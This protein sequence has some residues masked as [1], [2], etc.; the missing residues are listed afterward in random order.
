MNSF[1]NGFEKQ[2]GGKAQAAETLLQ[3]T[4]GKPAAASAE[5]A[6]A[7]VKGTG[8]ELK[9]SALNY[10]KENPGKAILGVGSLGL[11]AG[12]L[13]GRRSEPNISNNMNLYRA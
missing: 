5:K 12:Y 6:W 3:R 4:L 2:A 1:W 9:D 8:K 7:H 10:T 13:A 11:G